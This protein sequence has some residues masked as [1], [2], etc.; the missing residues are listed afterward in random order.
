MAGILLLE[1]EFT[2]LFKKDLLW[3]FSFL[4]CCKYF[5]AIHIS[6]AKSY[7][8]QTSPFINLF[9]QVNTFMNLRLIQCSNAS[10]N[11]KIS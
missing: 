1:V 9:I 7:Q 2:V 11:F 6:L 3:P 10:C 4:K 8:L 5:Q